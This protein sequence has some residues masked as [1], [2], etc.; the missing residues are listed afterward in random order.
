MQGAAHNYAGTLRREI[1]VTSAYA[2]DEHPR[3]SDEHDT[4]TVS[5]ASCDKQVTCTHKCAHIGCYTYTCA[6]I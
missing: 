3:H 2:K 5:N 4:I 6:E 1:D